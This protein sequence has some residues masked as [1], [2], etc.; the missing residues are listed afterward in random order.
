MSNG[1]EALRQSAAW[2]DVSSRGR[3]RATGEDRVGLLH[4]MCSN[5]IESLRPGEGSYGFFLN[6]QGQ[7]QTDSRIYVS[8]DHVLLDCEPER[9]PR[10]LRH[11]E[12]FIIMD[13][14]TLEDPA[15]RSTMIALEG[16]R[17]DSIAS[18]VVGGK[19][20]GPAPHSHN[21]CGG[22][23]MFRSSLSGQPGLWILVEPAQKAG[24]IRS[25]EAAGAAVATEEDYRV[26]RV[27]NQVPRCGSDFD[28][29]L[30]HE[31][32]QL[33]A[34]SFTKGCYLGQEIVERVRSRGQVNRLLV[35]L[36]LAGDEAPLEG[37]PVIVEDK[38]VG[39]LTS[40]AFSP[41]LGCVAGFAVLRR[42]AASPGTGVRVDGLPGR[43][44]QAAPS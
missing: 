38:E 23:R 18:E 20:P 43:V 5:D 32:Q 34:L 33:H 30:P 36:E 9:G 29:H 35:G 1:Y 11:L 24:L 15:P 8:E 41:R 7:I 27:E 31:T 16:P 3:I 21:S 42:E 4:A 40:P 25:L 14:V 37:S 28:N 19:L 2:L 6:A 44:R 26:V 39:W 10:L 12:K 13:D 22:V 17:A